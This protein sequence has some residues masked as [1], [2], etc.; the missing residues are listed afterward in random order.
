MDLNDYLVYLDDETL[1]EEVPFRIL[2]NGITGEV[3]V[4]DPT[5]DL[6]SVYFVFNI[7]K[8]ELPLK[9]DWVALRSNGAKV[10]FALGL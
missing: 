10:S 2:V 3:R 8:D 5:E 4:Y 9:G 6:E 1:N 7:A